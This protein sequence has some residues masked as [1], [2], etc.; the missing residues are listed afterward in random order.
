MAIPFP[1]CLF[2]MKKYE[3]PLWKM[4]IIYLAFSTVGLIGA[5]FGPIWARIEAAGVR[6]YGLVLFDFVLLLIMSPV[7]R[8]DVYR[9]GDFVA[10][11]IMAVCASAKIHC[12][13]NDCC[14][15]IVM[16]YKGD[17]PIHFPSVIVEMVIW[18]L[19]VALLLV[20]DRKK[21][22]DGF[23]WP[24]LMIWFGIIRFAVDFLRV[25]IW[26]RKPYVFSLTAGQFWSL[27][28]VVIGVGFMVFTFRKQLK[29]NPTFLE[30]IKVGLGIIPKI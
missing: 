15:G 11:P 22:K 24:A 5:R 4:L 10:P 3:I 23:M 30:A 8:V 18:F 13:M 16:C 6:L 1:L 26:E 14:K 25:S 20:V 2:R 19:F 28:S 27:V 9:L 21:Q 29:R 17:E 12:M 7:I